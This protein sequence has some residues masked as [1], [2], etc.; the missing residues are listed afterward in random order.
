MKHYL[1]IL[2][3]VIG[4]MSA[5]GTHAQARALRMAT[6]GAYPPFTSVDPSGKIVGWGI[7]IGNALCE[8]M[9]VKC[10][11]MAQDWNGLIPGLIAGKFDAID[12]MMA[13]TPNA[14]SRLTSRTS[15]TALRLRSSP[16]R[17]RRSRT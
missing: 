8:E 15:I 3:G 1:L 6:E 11:H 7:D 9:K 16:A 2:A 4:L 12:S 14:Q 17:M 10:Q 13:I 5:A